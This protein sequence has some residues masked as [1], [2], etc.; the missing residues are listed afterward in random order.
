[1]CFFKENGEKVIYNDVMF[2]Q[3]HLFIL[4]LPEKIL[5]LFC[6]RNNKKSRELNLLK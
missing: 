4:M 5:I 3:T 1:M 6:L 2:L